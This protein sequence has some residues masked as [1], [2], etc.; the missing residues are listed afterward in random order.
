MGNF[1][2]K[3]EAKWA[4]S[5]FVCLSLDPVISEMPTHLQ[6]HETE[7]MMHRF[8]TVIINATADLVA[9]FKLNISF[10]KDLAGHKGIDIY[11][12]IRQYIQSRH[13]HVVLINDVDAGSAQFFFDRRRFDAVMVHNDQGSEAIQPFLDRND[14]GV[15][16]LCRTSDEGS[17]AIQN[18]MVVVSEEEAEMFRLPSLLPGLEMTAEEAQMTKHQRSKSQP[19]H[20]PHYQ[21]VAANVNRFWNKK[22]NCGLLVS[23]FD[24]GAIA[25]VRRV[26]PKLPLFIDG[27]GRGGNLEKSVSSAHRGFLINSSDNILY[28]SQGEDFVKATRASV[29]E[30]DRQIRAALIAER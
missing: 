18:R 3:L 1:K 27:V 14:K 26:A 12:N 28:A 19:Y 2:Q 22:D 30:L 20:M 23:A 16:I 17:G 10:F 4:T 15:F 8:F 9:A 6:R 11:H 21:L 13:A 7:E 5:R 24:P 29:I 25:N